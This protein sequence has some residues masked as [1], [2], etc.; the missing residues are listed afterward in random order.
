[1]IVVDSHHHFWDPAVSDLPFLIPPI[2][3]PF[4]P[5]DLAPLLEAS[6]VDGTVIVEAAQTVD[7]TLTLLET[8]AE[9]PFVLG[10]VG[11]VD[12]AA[13]NVE[14]VL[15]E[16]RGSPGGEHLVGIRYR[17]NDEADADWLLRDEIQRGLAA[18]GAAG[19]AADVLVA[20]PHLAAATRTARA[21]PGVHFVVDHLARPAVLEDTSAWADGLEAL[22]EAPNVYCKLSGL[23]T[24]GDRSNWSAEQLLP[25]LCHGLSCFGP[26]RCMFGS[27][28]P[29][30]LLAADFASV[31]ALLREGIADLAPEEQAEVLG[32]TAVRAYRLQVPPTYA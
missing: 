2:D 24:R 7:E 10:V 25:Y 16:L 28:W 23:V 21:L 27:D 11:T 19:L 5:D 29:F 6:G 32:G 8:A 4:A 15:G 31:V 20:A 14:E 13:G 9:T 17:T 22:G 1:V 18:L 26:E 3:R 30:C 12:L